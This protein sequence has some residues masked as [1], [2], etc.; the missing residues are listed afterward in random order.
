M[1][2]VTICVK[3]NIV[4]KI[5]TACDSYGRKEGGNDDLLSVARCIKQLCIRAEAK[6]R[7]ERRR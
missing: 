5:V 7:K 1:G 6:D 2:T 4:R 3:S